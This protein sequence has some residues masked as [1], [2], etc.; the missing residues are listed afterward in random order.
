MRVPEE[1]L[2]VYQEFSVDTELT[3]AK[4]S[5]RIVSEWK[6]CKGRICNDVFV[7]WEHHIIGD[8]A[9]HTRHRGSNVKRENKKARCCE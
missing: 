4:G 3:S 7:F 5:S 8:V 9:R 2:R 1:S 6:L